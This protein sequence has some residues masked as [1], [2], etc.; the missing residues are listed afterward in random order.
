[1]TTTHDTIDLTPRAVPFAKRAFDAVAAAALTLAAAPLMAALAVAIKATDRGPV[2][3]RQTRV[4]KD[5]KPFR[6]F[7]FRTMVLN[8]E[9][10]GLGLA[11]AHNDDRIT[12]VGHL[13]RNTSLDELPQLLNV[14]RGEMSLVGPRPT[15]PSQVERYTDFQRQ[16]LLVR[17]GM[18][19]WAQING[20]NAL[21]WE[22]RIE[23]DV[24]YV[25]NWSF[26]L[27]VSILF[28]TL[29]VVLLREGLYGEDGVTT[30]LN[31]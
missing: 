3:F 19:G 22:R 15:V 5:G 20:R 11:V 25:R 6:V 12:K 28:R 18:S 7:K 21:S 17:P 13:L 2:F 23:L 24:W 16:R 8:A 1:M 14:L 26:A 9:Q 31:T 30:D 27:D 29:K 4:G 10:K